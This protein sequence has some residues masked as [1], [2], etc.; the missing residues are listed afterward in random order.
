MYYLRAIHST[1]LQVKN[2]LTDLE[3]TKNTY[4]FI[5]KIDNFNDHFTAAKSGEKLAIFCPEIESHNYGYK[6]GVSLCPNG[7]GTGKYL[8]RSIISLVCWIHSVFIDTEVK[9]K[10]NI[11][12]IILFIQ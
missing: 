1:L 5:W 9:T 3:T 2:I 8:V 7:D 6:I 4:Q 12:I 11:I 10:I